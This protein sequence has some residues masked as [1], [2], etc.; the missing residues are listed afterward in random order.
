[1]PVQNR[2][3]PES[4]KA[5]LLVCALL[6]LQACASTSS[7]DVSEVSEFVFSNEGFGERPVIP[8]PDAIHRL[9]EEQRRHFLGYLHSPGNAATPVHRRVY[10]YLES[11]TTGF[12]YHGETFTASEALAANS[13]NC[14]SL[15]IL[16]TAL[17]ELAGIEI[18]YE[19]VDAP[20]VFELNGSIV[21]KGIHV[22]SILYDPEWA[23]SEENWVLSARGIKIDYFPSKRERFIRNLSGNGYMAMYYRNIAAEAIIA[24]DYSKAYWYSRESLQY[25]PDHSEALNMLAVVNG[26]V[27]NEDEAEEIYLYGI[28]HAEEKLSLL[29]NYRVLLSRAGRDA[30]AEKIQEQLNRMDDPSPFHW[31]QLARSA[32]DDREYSRAIGYFKRALELAPYLHEV[33][34]GLAQAYYRAGRLRSAEASLERA[35]EKSYRVSTR[36][37]YEAKLEALNREIH[38]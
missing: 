38:N 27:G 24:G 29:K 22:R 17:A 19:L 37:L 8:G 14:L 18:G 36:S 28:A 31:F 32:Y 15:A 9:D 11:L 5:F 25:A 30:E 1:M 16:T 2:F 34:L 26:R 23:P 6:C 3:L 12:D 4:S 33:H 20:P 7:T 35:M 21:A 10:Y 13:G